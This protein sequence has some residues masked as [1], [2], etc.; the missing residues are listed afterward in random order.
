MF[1]DLT[2]E[3]C[4]AI[5]K[6][7]ENGLMT[8]T[9]TIGIQMKNL[10]EFK[11]KIKNKNGIVNIAELV[12][13]KEFIDQA[14]AGS[15]QACRN[16]MYCHKD[17]PYFWGRLGEKCPEYK[18]YTVSVDLETFMPEESEG[19]EPVPGYFLPNNR[20]L[21]EKVLMEFEK[22]GNDISKIDDDHYR[23]ATNWKIKDKKTAQ[24]LIKFIDKKYV[25]PY[26]KELMSFYKIK[27][28]HFLEDRMDFEFKKR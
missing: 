25:Q 18:D 1:D 6:T 19:K 14:I 17:S 13:M 12:D 7:V 20:V 21:A 9:D 28:V 10:E 8:P 22:D 3:H 11:F 26:V 23:E 2:Y 24:K 15:G 5:K 16:L 27:K 4:S